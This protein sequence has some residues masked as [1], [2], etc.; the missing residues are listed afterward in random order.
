MQELRMPLVR[1]NNVIMEQFVPR[2]NRPI[3]KFR[4]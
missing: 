1:G 3:V 4:K 2:Y